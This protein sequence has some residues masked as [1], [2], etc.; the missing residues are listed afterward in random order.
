MGHLSTLAFGMVATLGTTAISFYQPPPYGEGAIDNRTPMQKMSYE[1]VTAFG[2]GTSKFVNAVLS[3]EAIVNEALKQFEASYPEESASLGLSEKRTVAC[4][5]LNNIQPY[6]MTYDPTIG[7]VDIG[8]MGAAIDI[9]GDLDAQ[10]QSLQ[11]CYAY[12]TIITLCLYDDGND[13]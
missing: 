6:C 4:K 5:N 9:G 13:I 3:H 12:D 11:M 10:L 8:N 7:K 2:Q 1:L